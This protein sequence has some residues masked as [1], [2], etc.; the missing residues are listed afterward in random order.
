MHGLAIPV[1]KYNLMKVRI[2]GD[3]VAMGMYATGIFPLLHLNETSNEINERPKR[4]VF[5]DDFTVAGKLQEL[6]SWWDSIVSHGPNIGYYAKASK[7][8]LTVKERY[9]DG[10]IKIF[11]GTGVMITVKG[12]R[13][14]GAI[15]GSK[16]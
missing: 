15:V 4:Q 7:N 1:K 11:E 10:T 2:Q 6:R 13:H 3:S 16:E 14:R 12:G 5:A 9:F 8:W